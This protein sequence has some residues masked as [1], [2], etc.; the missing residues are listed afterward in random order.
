MWT[1]RR[2]PVLR[3]VSRHPGRSLDRPDTHGLYLYAGPTGSGKTLLA[4]THAQSYAYQRCVGCGKPTELKVG[5]NP[6][7][8]P[9]QWH[10]QL[11][12]AGDHPSQ[13]R[14][15][16]KTVV[17]PVVIERLDSHWIDCHVQC[18]VPRVP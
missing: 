4:V 8:V 15:E 6:S 16:H 17:R 14:T 7:V 18:R 3:R 2:R 1:A 10:A 13:L 12:E 9:T 5:P 11:T